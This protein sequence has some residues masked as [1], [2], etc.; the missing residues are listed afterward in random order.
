MINGEIIEKELLEQFQKI[1]PEKVKEEKAMSGRK[2]AIEVER[3]GNATC[4]CFSRFMSGDIETN[5]ESVIILNDTIRNITRR[6]IEKKL[7]ITPVDII[8]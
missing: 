3:I 7:K 1:C 2:R 4:R 5:R 8:R 6:I